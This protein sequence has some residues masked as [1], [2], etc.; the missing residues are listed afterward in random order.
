MRQHA[1]LEGRSALMQA[2]AVFPRRDLQAHY[3]F[4]LGASG[5]RSAHSLANAFTLTREAHP[6]S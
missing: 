4:K 6:F 5:I 3:R 1:S 2:N